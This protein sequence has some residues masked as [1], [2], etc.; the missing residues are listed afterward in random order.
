MQKEKNEIFFY[1]EDQLLS[2]IN[3][4]SFTFYFE[5]LKKLH[6]SILSA[7]A[8]AVVGLKDCTIFF[9]NEAVEQVFGWNPDDVIGKKTRLFYHSD[10]GYEEIG[11]RFYPILERRK[12][13]IDDF[14]C[15]RKDGNEILSRISA[16]VICEEMLEKGI[17][18][19]YEDI[20]DYKKI[21]DRLLKSEKKYRELVENASSIILRW[22]GE[23]RLPS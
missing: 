19:M 1:I 22:D 5:D 7:I 8:H 11:R 10:E 3:T 14:P 20:T 4:C 18:V 13:H 16:S 15:I 12:T 21:Q 6:L 17:V 9:A 2:K 23:V